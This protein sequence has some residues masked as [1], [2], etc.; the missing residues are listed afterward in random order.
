M[1]SNPINIINID[2]NHR[3]VGISDD[4]HTINE[5]IS[6][7]SLDY[8]YPTLV[9]KGFD[10]NEAITLCNNTEDFKTKFYKKY[11]FLQNLN[12]RNLLIAGGSIGD[13]VRNKNSYDIDIDFFVYDQ[14][15]DY[16]NIKHEKSNGKKSKNKNN[17]KSQIELANEIVEKWISNVIECAKNYTKSQQSEKNNSKGKKSHDKEVEC[18]II[19]NNNTILIKILS[20][21]LQLILRL[22]KTKSEV[23][24]GFDLGSSAIGFDGQ[25][26]YLTSLGKYCYEHSCN[27][28]D[29]TRRSTTYEYRLEKYF[30]R[31]F[32]IVIP[33]LDKSKLKTNYHKYDVS[34][35]CEL[36]HFVFSY[37]DIIGNKII[38]SI[39]HNRYS[40]TSDY[41]LEEV[42]EYNSS[43]INLYN[44]VNNKDYFYYTGNNIEVLK[45][46]P[47]ISKGGIVSFY[48]MLKKQFYNKKIDTSLLKRF[49]TVDNI[50]N[51]LTHIINDKHDDTTYADD[52]IKRQIENAL[53]KLQVLES[54]DHSKLNWKV[55]NPGSQISGS[56]NPIIEDE[57][58]WYGD[59]YVNI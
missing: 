15:N 14:D 55:D 23:L 53:M 12:M 27:I 29:T 40:V 13:I 37:D 44:L 5:L 26:V 9:N 6:D 49:I 19:R 3:S 18:E 42:S 54:K 52:L 39:F 32:N 51:I 24:H 30:N 25:E 34:E 8:D 2:K 59:L 11:G 20:V 38:V 46:A 31:G 57:K 50:T 10:Y 16:D 1:T 58:L 28:V 21:K 45:K 35:V 33:N 22:Y 36:P 48:E 4:L 41:Q 17:D 56:F 7:K 43:R 47:R